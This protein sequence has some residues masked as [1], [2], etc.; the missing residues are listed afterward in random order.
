MESRWWAVPKRT[1]AGFRDDN[2]TDWAAALTYYSVLAIFPAIVALVSILGLVGDSATQ[3]LL[4]NLSDLAPGAAGDILTGALEQVSSAPA[5]GVGLV[6]GLLGALWSAS[7]YV[8]AFGR[9][10]NAVYE[11]EEG[12]TFWKLRPLQVAITTLM[13]LLLALC[14]LA[15]VLT[16]PL[17][18]R[19][20]D[21]VGAGETAVA[22]WDI[23]KWPVILGVVIVLV[24]LLY[25]A[26]PNIR[27][28]GYRWITPGGACAVVLWILASAA[29]ALYVANFSSYNAT[30]GALAGVIV[31]LIWLWITNIAILFGVELDA[32][33]E[34]E[35]ELAAGVPEEETIAVP[36]R[37]PAL[38]KEI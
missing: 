12:R 20:G 7:G 16:G 10:A 23:A 34:R 5:A 17:A 1:F 22:L 8:G 2:L 6:L 33:L 36:P 4:S 19:V 31:F 13:I 32:E 29:F 9:A 38:G 11:V 37:A 27:H 28:P 15:V 3:P 21:V 35:R 25:Y 14:A 18:Q 24:S 30:Y 26:T